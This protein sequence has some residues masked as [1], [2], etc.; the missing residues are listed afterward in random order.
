MATSA[1]V[2]EHAKSTRW[3]CAHIFRPCHR[4][5]TNRSSATTLPSGRNWPLT[6]RSAT[7]KPHA[8]LGV[9]A[10][11]TLV[12]LATA[13]PTAT[14]RAN[15]HCDSFVCSLVADVAGH[16]YYSGRMRRIRRRQCQ[17]PLHDG[18]HHCRRHVPID[19]WRVAFGHVHHGRNLVSQRQL[20]QCA[21]SGTSSAA[22]FLTTKPCLI[23]RT[24][25]PRW[26]Q[27]QCGIPDH[28]R[29]HHGDRRLL[30][31]LWRR[32]PDASLRRYRRLG[33][34]QRLVHPYAE[35]PA[36]SLSPA[37]TRLCFPRRVLQA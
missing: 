28:Q 5:A 4:R 34:G 20:L 26:K 18:R 25:L 13:S 27:R 9:S 19:V 36:F 7:R 14:V 21:F 30:D 33:L 10:N 17:L 16:Y 32:Q 11:A 2:A 31:R 35:E 3:P 6:I 22:L 8:R 29:G 15:A 1:N 37:L 12:T 23:Y 24:Y